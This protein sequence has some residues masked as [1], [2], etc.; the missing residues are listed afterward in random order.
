MAGGHADMCWDLWE[1]VNGQTL[2]R[3]AGLLER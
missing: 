3:V 1:L 2:I